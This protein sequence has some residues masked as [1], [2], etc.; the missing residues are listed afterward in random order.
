MSKYFENNEPSVINSGSTTFCGEKFSPYLMY[1]TNA[2]IKR[3]DY[4]FHYLKINIFKK[5]EIK[6]LNNNI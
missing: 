2:A 6:K 4:E 5:T 3:C 1:V